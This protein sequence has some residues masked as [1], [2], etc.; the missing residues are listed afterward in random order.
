MRSGVHCSSE[1]LVQQGSPLLVDTRVLGS[2][3]CEQVAFG[4][5]GNHFD[6]VGQV[7][8]ISVK[9]V[10]CADPAKGGAMVLCFRSIPPVRVFGG[11]RV[12]LAFFGP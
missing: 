12:P 1:Q 10:V 11:R 6:D 5:I 9:S 8:T 7:L 4:L 2:Q 3:Q